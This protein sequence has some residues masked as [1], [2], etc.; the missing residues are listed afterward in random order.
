MVIDPSNMT[1]DDIINA[2]NASGL[3]VTYSTGTSGRHSVIPRDMRT[4]SYFQYGV[5]RQQ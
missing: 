4:Y 2:F 5:T 3:T 1:F